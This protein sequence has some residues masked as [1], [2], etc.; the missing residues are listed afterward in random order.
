MKKFGKRILALAIA[1]TLVFS[2]GATALAAEFTDMPTANHWAYKALNAA[3]TNNLLKGDDNNKLNPE[4]NLKRAEMAAIINRAFGAIQVSDISKFTDVTKGAWYYSDISKAFTMGI[5]TGY[6]T[7]LMKP[8]SPITRQEAFVV[9]ARA[10]KLEDGTTTALDK[11]SDKALIADWS[12]GALSAMVSAGY[13][14]GTYGKL[15]PTGNITRQEFAQVVY[16][17]VKSYISTAGTVTAVADGNVMV[18]VPG[19]TLKN[20]TVKGDLIVGDGVANGEFTLDN[21]K[22]EGRLV[23]RGGGKNSIKIINHSSVGNIVVS[24]SSDGAVRVV[25]DSTSSVEVVYVDDGKDG[26]IVEGNVTTLTIAGT[27][28]VEIKGAVK[29]VVVTEEA[30]GAEISVAA[31]ATVDNLESNANN[32]IVSG[33]GKVTAATVNGD[34][35]AINVVGTKVTVDK[36]AKGTT[37]NGTTVESGKEVVVEKPAAGSGG[38]G[39]G[40]STVSVSSVKLALNNGKS[41]SLSGTSVPSGYSFDLK[42]ISTYSDATTITSIEIVTSSN[43]TYNVDK[44]SIPTNTV[45]P[46]SEFLDMLGLKNT[47]TVS[48]GKIRTLGNSFSVSGTVTGGGS[49]T[50]TFDVGSSGYYS[51]TNDGTTVT[52]QLLKPNTNIT[53]ASGLSFDPVALL[54]ANITDK[55]DLTAYSVTYTKGTALKVEKEF[56][57]Y[58]S[59]KSFT[60]SKLIEHVNGNGGTQIA[61]LSDL[62]NSTVTITYG[63]KTLTLKFI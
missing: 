17:V 6:D 11:F 54:V 41:L 60:L 50:I 28:D 48:L 46:T 35:T 25:A 34:S 58:N 49:L 4:S 13:A 9:L 29:N 43:A 47:A 56:T 15:N 14:N 7:G 39:G 62:T 53:E 32:V 45:V 42:T 18:N 2:L 10:I 8:E 27:T 59:I 51:L 36:D 21:V 1:A 63:S 57:G 61:T 16:N 12:K 26:I 22:I 55:T 31:G 24:K 52:A 19:V 20:L 38:G 40:G 30:K 5:F 37:T 44:Y 3:V 33:E 23:V